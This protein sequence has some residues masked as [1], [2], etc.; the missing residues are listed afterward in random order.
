MNRERRP[1]AVSTSLDFYF[2]SIF[3]FFK[4][5]SI[6]MMYIFTDQYATRPATKASIEC[7]RRCTRL[8]DN[9]SAKNKKKSSL[10]L[11]FINQTIVVQLFF[12]LCSAAI[13]FSLNIDIEF[14]KT[15]YLYDDEKYINFFYF[16]FFEGMDNKE[17]MRYIYIYR[18]NIPSRVYKV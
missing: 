18:V 5:F 3:Y 2:F 10:Y 14:F 9:D 11:S 17:M 15:I 6:Y 1:L 4:L 8:D 16:F 12:C 13:F 7:G